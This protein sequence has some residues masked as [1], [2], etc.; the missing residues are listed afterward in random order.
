MSSVVVLESPSS[1][2][3]CHHATPWSSDVEI[4]HLRRKE[5]D[6]KQSQQKVSLKKT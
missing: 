4:L 6:T 2:E 3:V 1:R 5:P